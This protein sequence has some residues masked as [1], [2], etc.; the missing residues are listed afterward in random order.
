M[1]VVVVCVEA[2]TDKRVGKRTGIAYNWEVW[3]LLYCADELV[4]NCDFFACGDD[5]RIV[6]EHIFDN[7]PCRT[8]ELSSR[9]DSELAEF[10]SV[11]D[12]ERHFGIENWSLNEHASLLL[13]IYPANA[14]GNLNLRRIALDSTKCDG[15][16]FRYSCDGWG[17]IQ[18]YLES[19]RQGDLRNSHTN[20]NSEKR[21]GKWSHAYPEMGDPADWDWAA[22]NSYSRK[23]NR[24]IRKCGV[25]KI[26]SRVVLPCASEFMD[27][28][29]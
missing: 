16:T 23:L 1:R 5:H 3:S 15:A 28:A 10:T 7:L 25:D 14:G 9:F 18:L 2:P 12:V 26:D 6:L 27:A 21:A 4:P 13:T 17:L 22:V 20:H 8:F 24:F 19:P 29:K 11:A